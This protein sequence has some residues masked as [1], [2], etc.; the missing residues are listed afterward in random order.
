MAAQAIPTAHILETTRWF[1]AP[2][3][4]A[5]AGDP[6]ASPGCP[7]GMLLD[8][9]EAINIISIVR[10]SYCNGSENRLSATI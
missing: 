9:A 2:V 5:A 4:V 8:E 3:L 7:T 1:A 10:H 6:A